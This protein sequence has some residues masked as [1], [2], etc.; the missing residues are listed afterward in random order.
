MLRR[1]PACVSLRQRRPASQDSNPA[2]VKATAAPPAIPPDSS[3]SRAL[4]GLLAL[5]QGP[6]Q[7]RLIAL[8]IRRA[9]R[10]R[11]QIEK[12]SAHRRSRRRS[13]STRSSTC[14]CS[15]PFDVRRS[16]FDVRYSRLYALRPVHQPD[17]PHTASVAT[18]F[19][20]TG[21]VA[22]HGAHPEADA[23]S[24][25]RLELRG[26]GSTEKVEE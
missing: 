11:K 2:T 9:A 6:I 21:A 22:R 5:R 15:L 19:R 26:R 8:V 24:L 12:H 13:K 25:M 17:P 7:S 20:R 18:S 4:P 14:S 16:R 10:R 23:A 3:C 1:L